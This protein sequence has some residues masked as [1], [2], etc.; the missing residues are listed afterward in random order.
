MEKEEEPIMTLAKQKSSSS[1]VV[2]RRGALV[3]L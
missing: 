2:V 3:I 1:C